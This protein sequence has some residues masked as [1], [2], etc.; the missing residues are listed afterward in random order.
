M[1]NPPFHVLT[2]SCIDSAP[3][4]AVQLSLLKFVSCLLPWPNKPHWGLVAAGFPPLLTLPLPDS[5]AWAETGWNRWSSYIASP[6]L[7]GDWR[8]IVLSLISLMSLGLQSYLLLF[9]ALII[10]KKL[11]LNKSLIISVYKSYLDHG[12]QK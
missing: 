9:H 1:S 8:M 3:P 4:L 12:L 11:L 7:E 2:M 6:K 10:I 5:A